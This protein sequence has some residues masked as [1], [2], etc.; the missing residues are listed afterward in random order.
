MT[1]ADVGP[2]VGQ[3]AGPEAMEDALAAARGLQSGN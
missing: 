2:L 3:L 1:L